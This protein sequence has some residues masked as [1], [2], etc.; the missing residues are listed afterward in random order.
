MTKDNVIDLRLLLCLSKVAIYLKNNFITS[1]LKMKNGN[2]VDAV[3][4]SGLLHRQYLCTLLLFK[5]IRRRKFNI[6][7]IGQFTTLQHTSEPILCKITQQ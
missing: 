3:T 6:N 2:T 7:D 1:H 5:M 4:L